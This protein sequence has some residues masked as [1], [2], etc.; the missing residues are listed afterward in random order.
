MTPRL[1]AAVVALGALVPTAATAQNGWSLG[2]IPRAGALTPADWFFEEFP[3]FGVDPLEW[4]EA[5]IGRSGVAGVT[6]ELE[7]AGTGLWIRAEALRTVGGETSLTHAVLREPA[8]F[9]P[10][11]VVRTTYPVATSI[12]TGSLDL[13]LPL[14]F[15]LPG[16][17]PY[18]TAGLGGKRYAFEVAR[19]QALS[20]SLVLP[21]D[22]TVL[23]TNL[24]VGAVLRVAGLDLD[25]L[26]RDALSH[27]W[28][29]PQHDVMLLAGAR[30][31]L[32]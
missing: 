3:H 10:A 17:Q 15:T 28:D 2:I 7:V 24:G 9:E 29:A 21:R 16:I 11:R 32:H 1:A 20:D 23:L 8:G 13:G 12:T 26:V 19:L 25:L 22:G 27:Y 14:R 31:P 18:V 5:V 30:V 6:L 4:T